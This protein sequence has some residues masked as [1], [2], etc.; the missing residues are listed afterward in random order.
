MRSDQKAIEAATNLR[1]V[2]NEMSL[3]LDEIP[4]KRLQTNGDQTKPF[5]NMMTKLARYSKEL[6]TKFG[7]HEES[8][9]KDHEEQ[10]TF[11]K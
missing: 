3:E 9:P 4:M 7:V 6:V 8:S 10:K 2:F 1:K 11:I 5:K